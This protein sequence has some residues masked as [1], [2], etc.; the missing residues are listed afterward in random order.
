MVVPKA[1]DALLSNVK[2]TPVSI[3]RKDKYLTRLLLLCCAAIKTATKWRCRRNGSCL[4]ICVINRIVHGKLAELI[5]GE[6]VN[7]RVV[8]KC[9]WQQAQAHH[10]GPERVPAQRRVDRCA[11]YPSYRH[12]DEAIEEHDG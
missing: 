7:A 12:I 10:P 11:S 4:R 3:F 6:V 1:I 9:Y 2:A 5:L 8:A